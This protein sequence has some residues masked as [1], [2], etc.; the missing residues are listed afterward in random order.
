MIEA[1]VMITTSAGTS[2]GLLPKIREIEGVRRANVVAGEYDVIADVEAGSQQELLTL[3]TE[4]IQSLD[5]VGRTRSCV[6]L[7]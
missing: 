6:V 1:Y 2:R 5:G 3:V 4:E 7:E